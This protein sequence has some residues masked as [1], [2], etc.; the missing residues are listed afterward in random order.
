ML[1]QYYI[2]PHQ[3]ICWPPYIPG[4]YFS[5]PPTEA[6]YVQ[7]WELASIGKFAYEVNS[8]GMFQ[9]IFLILENFSFGGLTSYFNHVTLVTGIYWW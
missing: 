8:A 5:F 9:P 4:V 6:F 7:N 2:W 1:I 3:D